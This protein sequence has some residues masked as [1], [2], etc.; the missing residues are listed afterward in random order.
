[1][2]MTSTTCRKSDHGVVVAVWC[3]L[4][5]RKRNTFLAPAK[6]MLRLAGRR[7]LDIAKDEGRD[8]Y[9]RSGIGKVFNPF[10]RHDI[11]ASGVRSAVLK[12]QSGKCMYCAVHLRR[13]DWHID[14]KIPVSLGGKNEFDNYQALCVPC[15]LR[16]GSMTD[17]QFR[18][19][20]SKLLRSYWPWQT[21]EPPRERI[22]QS[23]FKRVTRATRRR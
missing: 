6:S 10:A 20:Y 7:A 16:K 1:M 21:P 19:R 4:P 2:K 18:R 15:N 23:A 12:S 14:H 9:Y 5:M 17:K 22:P 11:V 13:G 8:A 3:R